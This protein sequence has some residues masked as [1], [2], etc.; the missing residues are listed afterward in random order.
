MRPI[1][2]LHCLG[3]ASEALFVLYAPTASG[4]WDEHESECLECGYS[5]GY[6]DLEPTTLID[7]DGRVTTTYASR[8]VLDEKVLREGTAKFQKE[9]ADR[10]IATYG[11]HATTGKAKAMRRFRAG[12]A[13]PARRAELLNSTAPGLRK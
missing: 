11:P 5:Y 1:A 8:P 7:D 12:M 6:I 3:C 2:Y 13:D 4:A 10:L 9:N